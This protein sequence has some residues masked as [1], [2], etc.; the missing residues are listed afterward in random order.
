G[1]FALAVPLLLSGSRALIALSTGL[2]MSA[3]VLSLSRSAWVGG[4]AGTIAMVTIGWPLL[5]SHAR[6]LLAKIANPLTATLIAV[7]LLLALVVFVG[8]G[9]IEFVAATVTGED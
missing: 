5:R 3:L 1:L 9:G 8:S 4:V 2:M 6:V 7:P